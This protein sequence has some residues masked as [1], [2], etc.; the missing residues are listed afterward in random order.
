MLSRSAPVRNDPRTP[1]LP[2]DLAR[3]LQSY[4]DT[5]ARLEVQQRQVDRELERLR[6]SPG[7]SAWGFTRK[8]LLPWITGRL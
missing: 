8:D 4:R 5:I 6:R 7:F 2:S 3:Q 1:D